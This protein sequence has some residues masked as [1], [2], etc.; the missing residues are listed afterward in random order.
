MA[1]AV[2]F[3]MWEILLDQSKN[4]QEPALFRAQVFFKALLGI[5]AH[6]EKDL[7][8]PEDF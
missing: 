4:C 1:Q 8:S 6:R 5:E 2:V 3:A 7:R